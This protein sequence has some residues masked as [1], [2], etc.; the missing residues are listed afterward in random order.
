MAEKK[1]S[2]LASLLFAT[3]PPIMAVLDGGE[4]IA[5]SVVLRH[6]GPLLFS[7]QFIAQLS[8]PLLE[9]LL[10]VAQTL[11]SFRVGP[12][13][14]ERLT[15]EFDLHPNIDRLLTELHPREHH[16]H[17]PTTVHRGQY[18]PELDFPT[19]PSPERVWN[20]LRARHGR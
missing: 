19:Y 12:E 17:T 3:L 1:A 14:A 18:E 11:V 2:V 9:T 7:H 13:D 4:Q 6:E 8:E 15:K 5:P 16:I 10:G 20:V